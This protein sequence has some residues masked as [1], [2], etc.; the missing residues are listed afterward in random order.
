MNAAV[1]GAGSGSAIYSGR[2]EGF[3]MY[4]ARLV[5]QF[6]KTKLTRA[7]FVSLA[8]VVLLLPNCAMRRAQGLQTSNIPENT[9]VTAQKNL[10]ALKDFLDKNPHL[11]HFSSPGDP[12]GARTAAGSEQE[13]WKVS[14]VRP[15][16]LYE[17]LIL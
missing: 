12:G 10:F 1:A 16:L 2:R 6:W 13:A 11:F 14:N 9:L 15:V 4:F 7:G 8:N 17:I 5:R 3:A